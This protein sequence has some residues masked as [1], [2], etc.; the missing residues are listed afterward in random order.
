MLTP[1]RVE[2]REA[3]RPLRRRMTQAYSDMLQAQLRGISVGQYRA[4]RLSQHESMKE[5]INPNERRL[6]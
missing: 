1:I 3:R 6:L 5:N 2:L 4:M